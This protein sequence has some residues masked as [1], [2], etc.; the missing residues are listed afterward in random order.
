VAFS[1]TDVDKQL[2]GEYRTVNDA[3]VRDASREDVPASGGAE[4]VAERKRDPEGLLPLT[5][6]TLNILLA[7]A[8]EERH[9]YGIG[10][11]VRERT[12]GKMR[13]GPGTLYGSLKRM[14]DGGLVEES[15]GRTD[16]AP[17]N[18]SRGYDAERRRYYRLTGFGE[19]VLAAELARLDGVVR[20]AQ[21]KG[22]F[23]PSKRRASSPGEA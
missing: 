7:L 17:D 11:E 23:P 6:V 5:P 1:R 16:G 4:M 15:E 9:G 8:D 18:A 14:V 22:V 3:S 20:T 2:E 21:A 12:G 10:V 19:R 13:L